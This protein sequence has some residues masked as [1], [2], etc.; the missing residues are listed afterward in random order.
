MYIHSILQQK[1]RGMAAVPIVL[2]LGIM[3]VALAVGV[4]A[5]TVSDSIVA[6]GSLQSSRARQYADAGAH[7]ALIRIAR[8]KFYECTLPALPSGCYALDFVENGCSANKGCARVM[9]TSTTTGKVI[10]V[11]GR[12]GGNI[13]KIEVIA[14][15]DA[16]GNGEILSTTWSELTN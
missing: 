16:G 8:N 6:Q 2:A 1:E 4:T 13:R 15:L 3:I 14:T 11:D 9:V 7:D 5:M 10:L 12:V